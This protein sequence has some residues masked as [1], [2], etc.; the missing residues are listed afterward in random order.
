MGKKQKKANNEKKESKKHMAFNPYYIVWLLGFSLT[1][2]G[3]IYLFVEHNKFYWGFL[4]IF[5]IFAVA[6]FLDAVYY[7]FTK[8]EIYFVHFWGY[9]WRLPWF[10]VTGI[11]KHNFWCSFCLKNL[12]G[13]EV[14]YDKHHKGRL[15]RKSLVLPLTSKVKKC[16]K[17]FYRGDK[18]D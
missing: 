6:L 2:W 7:I 15:I 14:Y 9:K 11:I 4:L 10:Y 17:K 1:L 8:Q 12:M 13:Y 16:L 18:I 5:L 3:N